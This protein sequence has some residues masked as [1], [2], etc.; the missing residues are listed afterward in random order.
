MALSTFNTDNR[1]GARDDEEVLF[2]LGVQGGRGRWGEEGA[3]AGHEGSG[4]VTY[5]AALRAVKLTASPLQTCPSQQCP[6][7]VSNCTGT[8]LLFRTPVVLNRPV[9]LPGG[10]SLPL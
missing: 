1:G 3:E 2:S 10:S 8:L 5:G 9:W 4:G 7:H 6:R